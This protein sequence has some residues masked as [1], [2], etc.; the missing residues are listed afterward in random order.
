[1]LRFFVCAGILLGILDLYL[2]TRIG[3]AWGLL[4]VLAVVFLPAF[5][6]ARIA[7]RQGI[8][9]LARMQEQLAAGQMPSQ[10]IAEAPVIF[11]AGLLMLF[12]GPVTTVLGL[13]LL[14]PGL[15]RLVARLLLRTRGGG[16]STISASPGGGV[17]VQVLS[18]GGMPA[19]GRGEIVKDAEGQDLGPQPDDGAAGRP[20]LPPPK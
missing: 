7:F 5:F 16:V 17:R 19:G 12:P 1:M 10:T 15:R 4:A 8:R 14:I 11:M 3:E 6:G 9:C 13:L 18:I 2:L 20:E